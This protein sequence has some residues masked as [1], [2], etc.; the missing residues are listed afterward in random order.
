MTDRIDL[1]QI[2]YILAVGNQFL[3]PFQQFW[4]RKYIVRIILELQ[5]NMP[6]V[7]RCRHSG[8]TH[9]PEMI[10]I[11]VIANSDVFRNVVSHGRWLFYA[12][13]SPPLQP[14][15]SGQDQLCRRKHHTWELIWIAMLCQMNLQRIV[16]LFLYE[17]NWKG[18]CH[19]SQWQLHKQRCENGVCKENW[20]SATTR[21][22]F[23]IIE[24]HKQ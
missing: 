9:P 6:G 2:V 16:L 24:W 23:K 8:H 15:R 17:M 19:Q 10:S 13:P 12:L 4:L 11:L 14:G 20:T 7:Y 3:K 18:C 21:F 22:V 1:C 5:M